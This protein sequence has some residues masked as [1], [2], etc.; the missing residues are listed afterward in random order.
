[1]FWSYN[2][3]HLEFG[4]FSSKSGCS[5][6]RA[7]SSAWV[8]T[9]IALRKHMVYSRSAFTTWLLGIAYIEILCICGLH[10]RC[11]RRVLWWTTMTGVE[12]GRW[13][14]C[15]V[16]LY[17]G[18]GF[19]VCIELNLILKW[20]WPNKYSYLRLMTLN[21]LLVLTLVYS[22]YSCESFFTTFSRHPTAAE[23]TT[24]M[25]RHSHGVSGV[26]YSGAA[27]LLSATRRS[28]AGLQ[29]ELG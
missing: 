13:F 16:K 11:T 15:R 5:R 7:Y 4:G 28:G 6:L 26:A 14:P 29:Q 18:N 21:L 8:I 17:M 25:P 1:M 9:A 27:G 3:F 2:S 20:L 19:L 23:R 22:V 24:A 12:F 10:L